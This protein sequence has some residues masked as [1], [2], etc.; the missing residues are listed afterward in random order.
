MRTR[1]VVLGLL[2]ALLLVA[3]GGGGTETAPAESSAPTTPEPVA[4]VEPAQEIQ[5]FNW[6]EYIDP[7]IYEIFEDE[8]GIR[9]VESNFASNEE[10]LA[11]LQGGATGYDL[12]VPSDYTVAIMIEEG[13]LAELDHANI[14]NLENLSPRFRQVPYDPGNKYCVPYQWGTT[15]IGYNSAL[16]D[17]PTSWAVL[18]DPDPNAPYYGRAMMLDDPREGM[19]AA[20][21][22]L[23]YDINTTDEA[24]LEEAKQA[25]LRAKPALAG[26]DSD[27]FDDLLAAGETVLTHGWNGDILVAQEENLDVAYTIPQEGGVVWIDNVCI[28]NTVTPE[29]KKAAEIFINFLL[30]QDI[31]VLL[32]EFNYYASPNAAA[33]EMLDEEFLSDPAVYPPPQVLDKLQYIEPLGDFESVYQRIWDE[34]KAAR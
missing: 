20:L 22:Y 6:S 33:E 30:R 26:Y 21:V 10:M 17:E 3:C 9:V 34:V 24:Q 13:M 23:G 7:D 32:S 31:G 18:F 12:I 16:I 27:Q 25:L 5:F 11:K 2:V 29:R 4:E 15:G 28:P 14:P 19:A 1:L 8:Y